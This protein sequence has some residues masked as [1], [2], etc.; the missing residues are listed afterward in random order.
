M[1]ELR[2]LKT[3]LVVLP[4][5]L[6]ACA[7]GDN[8]GTDPEFDDA[9]TTDTTN[10]STDPSVTSSTTETT[11]QTTTSE[12]TT[13]E[14]MTTTSTETTSS[15]SD[16]NTDTTALVCGNGVI[17]SGEACDAGN[18]GGASCESLGFVGGSLQCDDGCRLD[19]SLCNSCGNGVAD[20]TEECDATDLR[21]LTSCADVML[22]GTDQ[23]LSCTNECRLDFSQCQSCGD[24]EVRPPEQCEPAK[25][26]GT[27]Q[28]LDGHTCVT[29]G[30][31]GGTLVCKAGCAL[32]SSG[33]YVCGDGKKHVLES[34]DGT[35]FGGATCSDFLAS[36]GEPF[37]RGQ[38][39]CTNGC[40]VELGNCSLCG[41]GEITGTEVC[42]GGN[43]GAATCGSLGHT[44]GTLA[45]AADCQ[46][47][48]ETACTDCGNATAQMGEDCDG[49]DLRGETCNSIVG[50]GGGTLACTSTCTYDT[51]QCD[52]NSCGDAILNGNDAC[53]C[54]SS[55][56]CTPA[57]L[58]GSTCA[59]LGFDGGTLDCKSPSLCEFDTSSCYK[60]GDGAINP[61]ES[62]DTADLNQKTCADFGFGGGTL[63]CDNAC[64]FDVSGCL[65]DPNPLRVCAQVTGASFDF[66]STL[67]DFQAITVPASKRKT[68]KTATVELEIDYP[69]IGSLIV[70]LHKEGA[71]KGDVVLLN[72]P[73]SLCIRPN[74]DAV[75]TDAAS[76]GAQATCLPTGTAI[77]GDLRAAENLNT[78][79]AGEKTDGK[80]VLTTQAAFLLDTNQGSAKGRVNKFCLNL[81]Y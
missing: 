11:T 31:D 38:L 45:C 29:Q 17:E 47:F 35:E 25:A 57:Q 36:N 41:D 16:T 79:F 37:T 10:M 66:F 39:A 14:T 34:C 70:T 77:R 68:I 80:W 44:A 30:F 4:L 76:Q 72:A 28:N 9:T 43:L 12:M 5:A 48:V 8:L 81:G 1:L 42:D 56:S 52:M 71:S 18:L 13:S 73:G 51:S 54:G 69:T 78:F 60:C 62:C 6:S 19:T 7:I 32:D 50:I 22:G 64:E 55:M 2:S 58:A 46:S 26:D 67:A 49:A 59:S 65:A 15:T 63:A 53:D 40:E 24:G 33:C 3:A 75:L 20:G 61:G 27:P 74:L 21:S 23:A